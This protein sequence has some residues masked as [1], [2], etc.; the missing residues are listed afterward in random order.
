MPLILS[1]AP[2]S[3]RKAALAFYGKGTDLNGSDNH[4]Q[5]SLATVGLTEVK[6]RS[7]RVKHTIHHTLHLQVKND[8]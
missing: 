7:Q 2:H 8:E 5:H 4:L 6:L 3:H 1:D